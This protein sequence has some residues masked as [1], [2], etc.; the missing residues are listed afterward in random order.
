MQQLLKQLPMY[1]EKE[2]HHV[3]KKVAD[4]GIV[5][6]PDTLL[7]P[8]DTLVGTTLSCRKF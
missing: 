8:N 4:I 3:I 2:H 5:W 7:Q 1:I 6:H